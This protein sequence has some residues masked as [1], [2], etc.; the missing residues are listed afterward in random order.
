MK[1]AAT[2]LLFFLGYSLYVKADHITGGQMSYSF[3]GISPEGLYKYNVFFKV[4]MRCNSG[5]EF[6]NPTIVSI[7]TKDGFERVADIA[8]P[9]TTSETI[10]L[11]NSN[12]CIT[13]PP[14]VC[15]EVGIYNFQHKQSP[16]HFP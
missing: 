11:N 15:Y 1:R 6:N 12:R 8:V 13:D 3:I 4:F 5:R 16:G 2:F 7:F 14:V 9:L 10:S